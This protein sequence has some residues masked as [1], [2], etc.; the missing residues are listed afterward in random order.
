MRDNIDLLLNKAGHIT[1]RDVGKAET[2]S[3]FLPLIFN[4]QS[5]VLED[6]E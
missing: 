3:V 1:N 6:S 5:P 2:F 4:P